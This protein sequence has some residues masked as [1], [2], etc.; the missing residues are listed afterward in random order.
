MNLFAC[1]A[2]STRLHVILAIAAVG[3]LCVTDI[4]HAVGMSIPAV[5]THLRLLRGHGLVK[6][7]NDGKNAF[8]TV[9]APLALEIIE[10][11]L[12]ERAAPG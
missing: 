9:N 2:E 6:R 8:Y 12:S 7:R 5:S 1:L 3:E 10:R 11:A 4:A